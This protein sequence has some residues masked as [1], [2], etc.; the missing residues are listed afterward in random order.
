MCDNKV[1]NDTRYTRGFSAVVDLLGSIF[2]RI[3]LCF[4]YTAAALTSSPL[5]DARLRLMRSLQALH[6]VQCIYVKAA[7]INAKWRCDDAMCATIRRQRPQQQQQQQQ[8][9]RRSAVKSRCAATN[10]QLITLS[11]QMGNAFSNT[12]QYIS[13]MFFTASLI[14]VVLTEELLNKLL[15]SV[16]NKISYQVVSMEIS[17]Y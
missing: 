12:L 13:T 8:P 3:F 11:D 1:L 6:S 5:P 10:H 9:L 15:Q 7:V 16:V 4:P 14:N 17:R 2:I